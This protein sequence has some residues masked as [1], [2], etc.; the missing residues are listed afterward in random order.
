MCICDTFDVRNDEIMEVKVVAVHFAAKQRDTRR[1]IFRDPWKFLKLSG[2]CVW[3]RSLSLMS[4]CIVWRGRRTKGSR[5][6]IMRI[7]GEVDIGQ[8]D[9]EIEASEPENVQSSI[10]E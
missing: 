7:L 1:F 10:E 6:E 4:R 3:P 8:N 9:Q 5:E 2:K